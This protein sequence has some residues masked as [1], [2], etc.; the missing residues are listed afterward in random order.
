MSLPA[1]HIGDA[2][3][4]ITGD[5]SIKTLN[6]RFLN[7]MH[8]IEDGQD[9]L[10]GGNGGAQPVLV[11]S[12]VPR[13]SYSTPARPTSQALDLDARWT[14]LQRARPIIELTLATYDNDI[15]VTFAQAQTAH[16]MCTESLKDV[17]RLAWVCDRSMVECANAFHS[18][19]QS[20]QLEL[21]LAEFKSCTDQLGATI[22]VA[23]QCD[24]DLCAIK[25]REVDLAR[26]VLLAPVPCR[27]APIC[28]PS[29]KVFPCTAASFHSSASSS[30]ASAPESK[31]RKAADL[32]SSDAVGAKPK[33][34]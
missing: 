9:S 24:D 11:A 6:V 8:G 30:V 14:E 5:R 7:Y 12:N 18:A 16:F 19:V 21:L 33:R 20:T 4:P 23:Q 28:S 31:K 2:C 10:P 22:S 32:P 26:Q 34:R 25:R 1:V 13:A 27:H 17:I 15:R 3:Y 29:S